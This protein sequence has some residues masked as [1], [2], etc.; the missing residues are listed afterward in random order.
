MLLGAG[1][2]PS[3]RMRVATAPAFTGHDQYLFREGT[4]ARLYEKLGAHLLREGGTRFAVWAPNAQ[5]VSVVG[6][7]NGWDPRAHPLKQSG[8]SSGIWQATVPGAKQGSVYKF[9]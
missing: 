9:H 1:D 7:F 3:F 2:T 4:H 6:D 8:D 5:S